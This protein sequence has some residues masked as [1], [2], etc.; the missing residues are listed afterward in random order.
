[1]A[2]TSKFGFT[3]VTPS[4]KTITPITL[5]VV[6]S[7]APITDEPTEVVLTNTTCPVDQG[8]LVSY[9]ASKVAKVSTTQDI[10]N[11]D[12]VTTGVQYVVK[13]EEILS[14]TSDTDPTF[15]VDTPIVAYLTIRHNNSS[16]VTD[17]VIGQVVNRLLGAS[18]KADGTY[19]FGDLMRSAL[20]PKAN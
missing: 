10:R 4:S 15:R 8:E 7:Y 12:K 13:V 16:L 19:R 3:N 5:N 20:K 14:T 17:A 1:M 9:K 2:L 6:D 11:P 18:M